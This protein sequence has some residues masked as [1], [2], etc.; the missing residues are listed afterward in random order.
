VAK[1]EELIISSPSH[2]TE[3]K[4]CRHEYVKIFQRRLKGLERRL[5]ATRGYLPVGFKQS[6]FSHL[7][8]GSFCF[9][10]RCR[11]RLYPRRSPAEKAAARFVLAQ[12]KLTE[13]PAVE[14]LSELVL[15]L[16]EG[17]DIAVAE[18]GA[19]R[20]ATAVNVEELE[21]ESTEVEDLQQ[22]RVKLSEEEENEE[23]IVG[24]KDEDS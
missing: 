3:E 18:T 17:H 15:D 20:G 12:N 9:C 21:Y 16:V 11:A 1:L 22:D 23:E 7:G 19:E 8:E 24:P 5:V 14:D 2:M 10:A 13:L 4:P 6:D